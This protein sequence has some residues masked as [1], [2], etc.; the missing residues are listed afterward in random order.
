MGLDAIVQLHRLKF[1]SLLA[2][3]VTWTKLCK[4]S[5][6]PFPPHQSGHYNEVYSQSSEKFLQEGL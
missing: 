1:N 5:G 2:G 4:L 6:P 3:W